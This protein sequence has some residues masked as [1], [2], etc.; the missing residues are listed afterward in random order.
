[1]SSEPLPGDEA[2]PS[3]LCAFCN[4]TLRRGRLLSCLH[5]ICLSCVRQELSGNND[6]ACPRCGTLTKAPKSGI[7]QLLALPNCYNVHGG[8]SNKER[9]PEQPTCDE[10]ADGEEAATTACLDCGLVYCELHAHSHKKSR[11]TKSHTLTDLRE[12]STGASAL[13]CNAC[14]LHGAIQLDLYCVQCDELFCKK[15]LKQGAHLPHEH[16]IISASEAARKLRQEIKSLR[17]LGAEENGDGASGSP[18]SNM[19]DK[20]DEKRQLKSALEAVNHSISALN[21][22]AEFVSQAVNESFSQAMESAKK[23]Q[24]ALIDDIDKDRW[25]KQKALE[26]QKQQLERALEA[27]EQVD[28]LLDRCEND[29]DFLRMAPWLNRLHVEISSCKE[30]NAQPAASGHVTFKK[31]NIAEL[32]LL[33]SK[34]GEIQ[35]VAVNVSN[36]TVTCQSV[37]KTPDDLD[38]TIK[39][40]T[41]NGEPLSPAIAN[42]MEF[43][44]SVKAEEG[45]TVYCEVEPG[46][47][48]DELKASLKNPTPGTYH[49]SVTMGHRHLQGSPMKVEVTDQVHAPGFNPNQRGNYLQLSNNNQTVQ[50]TTSGQYQSVCSMKSGSKGQLFFKVRIDQ[51]HASYNQILLSV[52]CKDPPNVNAHDA[53][54]AYGWR[55]YS[56]NSGYGGGLSPTIQQGDVVTVMLDCDHSTVTFTLERTGQSQIIR[57]L[58]AG[59]Y[60][61]YLCLYWGGSGS[62]PQVTLC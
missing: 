30:R 33:A 40:K 51:I 53:T 19:A 28:V 58:T 26:D 14:P 21:K 6:I 46:G 29:L 1:M 12:G 62:V 38:V 45:E 8:E 9:E 22:R 47:S 24:Q 60:Y 7:S 18:Q 42:Q 57:N 48:A 37:L 17:K 35:D 13:Q 32:Q 55:L 11:V 59:T 10:C 25:S 34:A 43:C 23:R 5:N 39:A 31:S 16:K 27:G 49:V 56:A 61:L 50:M 2:R 41:V 15:C 3:D 44:I 36:S 54:N 52:S 20:E 4:K